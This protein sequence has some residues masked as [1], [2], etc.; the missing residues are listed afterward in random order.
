MGIAGRPKDHQEKSKE[1]QE[2]KGRTLAQ[3]LTCRRKARSRCRC[4]G[5]L[6]PAKAASLVTPPLLSEQF[7][8]YSFQ[9][10]RK[11]R[12]KKKRDIYSGNVIFSQRVSYPL[13]Q[14]LQ[15]RYHLEECKCETTHRK[16]RL[17]NT[18]DLSDNQGGEPKGGCFVV[19]H[20]GFP[21]RSGLPTTLASG[22]G[23]PRAVPVP[24]HTRFGVFDLVNFT[25]QPPLML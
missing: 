1:R 14:A 15:Q 22:A 3:L 12:K 7:P 25:A 11:K 8:Y 24:S 18:G 5:K 13:L 10:E 6:S 21:C 23:G 4:N 2:A 20:F 19:V 17:S 16:K 9:K